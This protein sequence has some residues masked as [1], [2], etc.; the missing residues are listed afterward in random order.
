MARFVFKDKDGNEVGRGEGENPLQAARNAGIG[1]YALAVDDVS[2][3]TGKATIVE[4]G[5]EKKTRK[6]RVPR[7]RKAD[8]KPTPPKKRR[9][10]YHLIHCVSPIESFDTKKGLDTRLAEFKEDLSEFKVID[11]GHVRQPE[12]QKTFDLK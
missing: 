4:L 1:E 2:E 5:P 11:G 3:R 12:C 8:E 10:V 6:T 7:Q 9:K